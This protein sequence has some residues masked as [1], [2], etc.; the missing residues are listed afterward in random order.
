VLGEKTRDR[1]GDAAP[2][3]MWQ[4]EVTNLDDL[5]LAVEVV[6]HA[7]ADNLAAGSI[8]GTQRQQSP[9]LGEDR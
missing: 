2:T 9:F 6:Q 8:D 4:N 3:R 5:A 1:G 7:S